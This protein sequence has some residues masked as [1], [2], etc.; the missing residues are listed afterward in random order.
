MSQHDSSANKHAQIYNILVVGYYWTT[1]EFFA[2][3]L[4][5]GFCWLG[6]LNC[7]FPGGHGLVSESC[8]PLVEV[9]AACGHME[10]L[11]VEGLL[12]YNKQ[13]GSLTINNGSNIADAFL[14]T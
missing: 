9:L 2:S 14:E 1:Y 13:D 8:K 7:L 4:C 10:V 11:K 3:K 6:S 5:G 12:F